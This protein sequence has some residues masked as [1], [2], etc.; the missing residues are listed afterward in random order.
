MAD[1]RGCVVGHCSSAADALA[2]VGLTIASASLE[3]HDRLHGK[4]RLA[5]STSTD[6]DATDCAGITLK[7]DG[8]IQHGLSFP[9]CAVLAPFCPAVTPLG[10]RQVEMAGLCRAFD[11]RHC[12]ALS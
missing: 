10:Q 7:S 11:S 8:T 4:L 3:S 6:V 5:T 2:H 1:L 9:E 12:Q